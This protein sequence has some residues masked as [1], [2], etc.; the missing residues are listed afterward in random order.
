MVGGL[1]TPQTRHV[2][3]DMSHPH[4]IS[5]PHRRAHPHQ[6]HPRSGDT[7]GG[8]GAQNPD[9]TWEH[10]R[11]RDVWMVNSPFDLGFLVS[12]ASGFN[13]VFSARPLAAKQNTQKDHRL[14]WILSEQQVSQDVSRVGPSWRPEKPCPAPG[15]SWGAPVLGVLRRVAAALPSRTPWWHHRLWSLDRPDCLL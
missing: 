7:G 10:T 1:H 12:E 8:S 9:P 2:P 13:K 6:E 15:H 11:L 14:R 3:T 4:Q 5:R